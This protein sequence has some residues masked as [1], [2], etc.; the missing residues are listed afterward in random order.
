MQSVRFT[1]R[2]AT[3]VAVA[4]MYSYAHNGAALLRLHCAG[5]RAHLLEMDT[6]QQTGSNG[7]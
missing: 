7:I 5:D 1:L 4:A 6:L 3:S 2:N